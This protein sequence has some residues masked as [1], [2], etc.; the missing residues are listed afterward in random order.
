MNTDTFDT[1]LFDKII[2]C[3]D[4]MIKEL[5]ATNP[6]AAILE[7]PF[8]VWELISGLMNLEN[9]NLDERLQVNPSRNWNLTKQGLFNSP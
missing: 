5:E 9:I 7:E 2:N 3:L 8:T 1:E 6:K 4:E